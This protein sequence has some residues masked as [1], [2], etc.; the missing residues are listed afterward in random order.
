MRQ[1]LRKIPAL[2]TP[3]LGLT[4]IAYAWGQENKNRE[5]SGSKPP[6][7]SQN[8]SASNPSATNDA[9]AAPSQTPETAKDAARRA[10]Q[11]RHRRDH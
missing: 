11:E 5:G 3:L 9:E 2:V 4:L 8:K 1:R 6:E 10:R 7:Q